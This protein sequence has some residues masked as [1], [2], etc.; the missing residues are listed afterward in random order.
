MKFV[1]GNADKIREA[2]SILGM[3]LA[4]AELPDIHEIQTADLSKLVENKLDQ[5][6][7]ALRCPVM[8]EDSA[9]VFTA[10][11]GLP[12]ALVK[13]FEKSVGCEGMIKMLEP[14][15]NR[16]ALAL[17]YVA[18]HDGREVRIAKGEVRGNIATKPR[19]RNGFGWDVIFIPEGYDR[20]YAEMTSAEKNAISHRKRAFEALKK[21]L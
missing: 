15:G 5:A 12:G 1:T 17:C 9:L 19:G 13:W 8:V 3:P 6:Y 7:S 21:M 2:C 18:L 10:W 20:T 4:Q 14:F 16:E 11:N